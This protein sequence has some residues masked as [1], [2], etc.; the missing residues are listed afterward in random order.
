MSSKLPDSLKNAIFLGGSQANK[1]KSKDGDNIGKLSDKVIDRYY[2]FGPHPAV[3]ESIDNEKKAEQARKDA[4]V[5]EKKKEEVKEVKQNISDATVQDAI[6]SK[7]RNYIINLLETEDS[8]EGLEYS[9][10]KNNRI[11][12]VDLTMK[13]D[14][15]AGIYFGNVFTITKLPSEL[16]NK[17]LFQVKNVTHTVNNDTWTTDLTSLCRITNSTPLAIGLGDKFI[18]E[19]KEKRKGKAK[20]EYEVVEKRRAKVKAELEADRIA[21]AEKAASGKDF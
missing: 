2:H 6:S 21:K 12:P 13:I 11:L 5:A 7:A 3:S 18:D 14:G 8:P 16:K 17:L 15:I 9:Q 4:A 19:A 1:G 20:R 10:Y